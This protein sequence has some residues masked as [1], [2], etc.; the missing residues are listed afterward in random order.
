MPSGQAFALDANWLHYNQVSITGTF[1][2]TP[3]MLQQ[4]AKVAAEKTTI[5]LSKIVTHRY[6]LAEIEQAM[7]ATEKYHGLRAVINRF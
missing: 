6:P 7:V 4:A 3:S 1:S 2:S 5:D